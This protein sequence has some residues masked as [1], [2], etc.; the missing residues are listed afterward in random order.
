MRTLVA[1]AMHVLLLETIEQSQIRATSLN[2]VDIGLVRE[3][4]TRE[5]SLSLSSEHRNK[6]C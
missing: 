4:L 5:L 6:L 2:K 1:A 3:H